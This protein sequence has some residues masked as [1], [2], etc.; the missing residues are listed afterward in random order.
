MWKVMAAD[1]ESYIREALK[2]LISWE[3]MDCTL[4]CV[5]SNGAQLL[6]RIREEQ[7]DIVIT[8]IRMPGVD[9][10][11]V[12]RTLY[13]TCPETQVI[14]LSAYSEF[15]YAR[16]A[17]RYDV[18]EYVLKIAV[19]EELPAAVEKAVHNL[20]KRSQELESCQ[21]DVVQKEEMDSLYF[22][23]QKYIEENYTKKISLDEIAE[24]LHANRSYLSRLYKSK[25]GVNLFD[26]I[27][28]RRIELA[29]EYMRT[30]DR[31]VYEISQAVG[32]DDTGYFSKVFKKLVGMSPKEYRNEQKSGEDN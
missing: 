11:S 3:K 10:L 1:D 30:T 12:C 4:L 2:N 29:K 25:S 14:L 15:D 24:A 13:E 31:K 22:R 27:L 16:S 17:I 26:D 6:E 23:M 21:Q 9:G 8:D 28:S 19:L 18:C 20:K 7:P 32:F 5:C